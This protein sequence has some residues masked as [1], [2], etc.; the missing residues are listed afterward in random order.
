MTPGRA[1]IPASG[2]FPGALLRGLPCIGLLGAGSLLRRRALLAG[3]LL[4]LRGLGGLL[5][6]RRLGL[7]HG[8]GAVARAAAALP[9]L[10]QLGRVPL[11][12]RDAVVVR[13]LLARL[14]VADRLDE[15][16]IARAVVAVVFFQ[17][18]LAVGRAAV[19][20]PAGGSAF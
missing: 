2:R 4:R 15:D 7:E 1:W 17:H 6:R 19:V 3:R 10:L 18:G 11:V 12:E 16:A 13:Q 20:D 14:D 9:D 5:L 8:A